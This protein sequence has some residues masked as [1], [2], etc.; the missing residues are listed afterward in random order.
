MAF[1]KLIKDLKSTAGVVGVVLMNIDG[2]PVALEGVAEIDGAQ[3][4]FAE[5]TLSE[6]AAAYD[7]GKTQQILIT[8]SN[9]KILTFKLDDHI[10][11]VF[12]NPNAQIQA[13]KLKIQ[14]SK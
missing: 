12:M 13:V 3:T 8:G 6:V 1:E 9:Y 10:V 2:T 7:L 5:L 4:F 11:I 14:R